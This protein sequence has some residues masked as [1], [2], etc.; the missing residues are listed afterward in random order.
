MQCMN[1]LLRTQ[2]KQIKAATLH[3]GLTG[4]SRRLRRMTV[5]ADGRQGSEH[6]SLVDRKTTVLASPPVISVVGYTDLTYCL[7]DALATCNGNFDLPELV[8]DLLRAVTFPWHFCLPPKRPV[9]D[10]STGNI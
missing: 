1:A 10:F 8:Q 7:T 5:V 2:V 6:V 4:W 9:S 3:V